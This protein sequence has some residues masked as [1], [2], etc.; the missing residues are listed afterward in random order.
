[1][2]ASIDLGV[3]DP[4]DPRWAR[5]AGVTL[6]IETDTI[7]SAARELDLAV[8]VA[9]VYRTDPSFAPPPAVWSRLAAAMPT[10]LGS[11]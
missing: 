4:A 5:H 8:V 2:R 9:E 1:V 11:A 10:L 7:E 6:P 3:L